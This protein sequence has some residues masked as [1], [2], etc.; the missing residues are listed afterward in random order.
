MIPVVRPKASPHTSSPA[1]AGAGTGPRTFIPLRRLVTPLVFDTLES[2]ILHPIPP[3]LTALLGGS[4][5]PAPSPSPSPSL[6]TVSPAKLV[7]SRR[8]TAI[9]KDA[10]LR[11]RDTAPLPTPASIRSSSAADRDTP[12][13]T[14]SPTRFV[15]TPSFGSTPKPHINFF[16][17]MPDVKISPLDCKPLSASE[18]TLIAAGFLSSK[19]P[20]KKTNENA[21]LLFALSNVLKFDIFLDCL[22]K[23][24]WVILEDEPISAS[25]QMKSDWEDHLLRII[26]KNFKDRPTEFGELLEFFMAYGVFP[27]TRT[28]DVL[29]LAGHVDSAR[30]LIHKGNVIPDLSTFYLAARYRNELLGELVHAIGRE[31][32][33]DLVNHISIASDPVF[34]ATVRFLSHHGYVES[35]PGL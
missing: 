19:D 12:A 18:A 17:G 9:L 16:A 31:E 26:T 8:I 5:S 30:I 22:V 24:K 13:S 11:E 15:H 33:Q 1:A 14:D 21:D 29:I 10:G 6:A 28:L 4:V 2:S 7:E 35:P 27:E 34:V 20:I 32:L 25:C 3:A 23:I